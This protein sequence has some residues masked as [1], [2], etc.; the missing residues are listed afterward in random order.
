MNTE[1]RSI[2]K[3]LFVEDDPRDVEM[4][5]GALEKYHLADKVVVEMCIRDRHGALCQ[6]Q[7]REPAP[8]GAAGSVSA[9]GQRD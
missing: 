3:I 4:T 1:F 2:K 5:L 9:Q 8:I 6:P 7:D